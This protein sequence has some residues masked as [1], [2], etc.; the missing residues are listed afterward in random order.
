MLTKKKKLSFEGGIVDFVKE[1]AGNDK[2]IDDVI[3]MK[4]KVIL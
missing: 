4:D 2:I 1:I 3:Y